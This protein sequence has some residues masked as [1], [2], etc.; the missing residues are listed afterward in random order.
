MCGVSVQTVSRVINGRPDVSA[1]TRAAVEAAIAEVGFQPSAVARSLVQR[2]SNTLGLIAAGLR[3]FGVGQTLNG[4]T[5]ASEAAGYALLI[6]ELA[7]FDTVDIVPVIDFLVAHRV[8]G[9]IYAAPELE[10]NVRNVQ[11]QL[12]AACPPIVFLK[13]QPSEAH[14]TLGIDNYAGGRRATDHLVALGRRR[15]GHLSGPLEW[16]E[17]RDRRDGW[18]DALG[19]AELEPGPR[20]EGTWSSASGAAGFEAMLDADPRLDAVFAGND[21][22]ALGVLHVAH[23]RGIRI[24]DDLA[25]VGFDGLPESAEFTP[26]LTTVS[27]PLGELGRLAV[28]ELLAHVRHE[29]GAAEV[30]TIVLDAELI[31]RESAPMPA[32][33]GAGAAVAA[34]ADPD[35]HD[36]G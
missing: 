5:E 24:P 30:R 36:A 18:W 26:S 31:V 11:A 2:R 12:P 17:A 1:E 29:T 33:A 4:I 35:A 25:V 13:S 32:G 8:E 7:S 15:I 14:T 22:M 23:R 9:I 6:K 21:Q 16:R 10:T 34:N 20:V 3:Y 19:A 27:Q 28:D